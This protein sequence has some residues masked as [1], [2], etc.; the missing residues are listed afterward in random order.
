VREHGGA[1]T[2]VVTMSTCRRQFDGER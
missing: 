2:D 1:S